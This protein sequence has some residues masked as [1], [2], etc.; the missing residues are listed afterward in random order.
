MV[1]DAE[2]NAADDKRKLDLANARNQGEAAVHSVKK[3]MTEH[4]DKVNADEKAAIEAAI[5]ELETEL[6]TD[7][8]D[9]IE[10]AT[11][12]LMTVSQKL[13]EAVY[14]DM[15][16][17]QAAPGTASPGAQ[18]GSAAADDNVVDADFKEVKRGE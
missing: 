14:A 5:G 18:E 13:G 1:K 6:K 2:V 8:K 10:A 7:D 3:S 12:K 9:K 4:A 15:Q 11:T 17:K 16:A